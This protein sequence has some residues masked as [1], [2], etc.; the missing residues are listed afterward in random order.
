MIKW[1]KWLLL[2]DLDRMLESAYVCGRY[3]GERDFLDAVNSHPL[4]SA[5]I[6][7]DGIVEIVH[8]PEKHFKDKFDWDTSPRTNALERHDA[9]TYH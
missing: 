2:G 3:D 8:H 7:D 9:R 4:I 5:R 6:T 1:L